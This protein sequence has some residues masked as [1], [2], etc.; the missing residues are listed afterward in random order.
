[1]FGKWLVQGR[2]AKIPLSLF[3]WTW[4]G[5]EGGTMEMEWRNGAK[6]Q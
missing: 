4:V 2:D 5:E 3:S 1:M 6:G